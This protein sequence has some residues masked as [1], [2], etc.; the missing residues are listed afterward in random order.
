MYF[1]KKITII[2]LIS[3]ISMK[4]ILFNEF[5]M[6]ELNNDWRWN[7]NIL[8]LLIFYLFLIN[9]YLIKKVNRKNELNKYNFDLKLWELGDQQQYISVELTNEIIN[10][11]SLILNLLNKNRY[12]NDILNK[13]N[14]NNREI[15][16]N[17]KHIHENY[18][19]ENFGVQMNNRNISLDEKELENFIKEKYNNIYKIQKTILNNV[20]K[21]KIIRNYNNSKRCRLSS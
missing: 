21:R 19:F 13:Y 14:N 2:F 1:P 12:R 8:V 18:I 20:R 4:Y 5:S 15:R 16:T 9:L 6:Y 17:I 11:K 10:N 7:Y 3:I